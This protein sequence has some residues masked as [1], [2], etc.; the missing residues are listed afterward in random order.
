M[1]RYILF[2]FFFIMNLY[3]QE[4]T[5]SIEFLD[6]KKILYNEDYIDMQNFSNSFYKEGHPCMSYFE[7]IEVDYT[8]F[9]VEII[10]AEYVL[11]EKSNLP[12]VIP[13]ELQYQYTLSQNQKNNFVSLEI[14]P[15][16]KQSGSIYFLKS[17]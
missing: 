13:K 11:I 9:N 2:L 1:R 17:F 7:R 8:N 6:T 5:R 15:Y 4:Y 10:D 3:A 14:F 16:T 12:C